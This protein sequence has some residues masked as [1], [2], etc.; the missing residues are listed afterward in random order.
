MPKKLILVIGGGAAGHQIAYQLRDV[1]KV[2]LVDPKTYWE[3]PMAVPRLLVESDALA[4]RIPYASFLNNSEHVQGRVT[5][6][7]DSHAKVKLSDDLEK[8]VAFDYAVIASGSA[9]LD[10]IIKAQASTEAER[11]AELKAMNTRLRTARSVVIVGAG[12]VGVETAAE[13]REWLPHVDVTLV[14]GENRALAKAPSK[15]ADWAEKYLSGKGVK[16]VLGET[17]T[18][19]SISTQPEDG[20]VVTSSGRVLQAEVVIWAAGTRPVTT[21][22]ANSWSDVVQ[23]NGLVRVDPYLRVVGHSTIF[24]VGDV[25]NLPENR[26]AIVAGL[27]V[28]SVVGNLKRLIAAETPSQTKLKAYKPALPGKGIGKLMIVSLGRTDGLTSLPFGQFRASFLARKIKSHDLLV[29][30]SRKAVGLK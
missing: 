1:A 20:R 10:P 30:M 16:L 2:T 25:T 5:A 27:H 4:A 12:P 17:V 22:V 14:H 24:A 11:A 6:L 28:K 19:P 9:S 29:G 18:S 23:P 3:I 13:L 21:F 26:L 8:E 7:T 15:F